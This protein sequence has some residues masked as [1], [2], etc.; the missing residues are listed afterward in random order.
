MAWDSPSKWSWLA[1]EPQRSCL[2]GSQ[3]LGLHLA[4]LEPIL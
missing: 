2:P 1:S 3:V 4:V